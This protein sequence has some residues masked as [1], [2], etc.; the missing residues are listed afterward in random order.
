MESIETTLFETENS[1]DSI[2]TIFSGEHSIELALQK[3]RTKLLD[4][5]SR[6]SLICYRHPKAKSIQFVDNP[7]INLVFNR[8]VDGKQISIKHVPDPPIESYTGKKPDVKLHAQSLG[9]DINPDIPPKFC[10]SSANKHT[11][12]IQAPF[13][14]A[15]LDRLCR[16]ISSESRTVIE[17]TGSN[18]LYLIC[19]FLEFY[20][21]DDSERPFLAPLLAVPITLDKTGIDQET[22]TYQYA[23]SYSGEDIHENQTLREKLKEFNLQ[24]PEYNDEDEP[25]V[26]FEELAK[27]VKN[28]KRWKVKYQITL[29]FLSFAKLAIW[30][31]LD[32]KK[33][34]RLL[35]HPLLKDLFNGGGSSGASLTPEDYDIDQHP[36]GDLPLIYDADSSQ[37]SA[38]IDVMAGKNMVINGPP[39][40][41]KSQTITNI[42]ASGLNA[43]KKVLFVSEKMAAL[44]VVKHR[45]NQ[46]NLGHFCLELHS[47]KT[48]KK[49]I[50]NDIQERLD[51]IFQDPQQIQD[52]LVTLNR[53]KSDL[54]RYVELISSSF[55]NA[56]GLTVYEIFWKTEKLRQDIGELANKVQSLH[57]T[58]A[59][60]WTYDCIEGKRTKLES[61]GNLFAIIGNYD[62]EH[63]WWGFVPGH[64][65]PGDDD[66]IEQIIN[67]A[68]SRAQ[69]LYTL[70][71][72]FQARTNTSEEPS[73]A[74][75]NEINKIIQELPEPPQNIISDILPRIF[76]TNKT[77]TK[78]NKDLLKG[79]ISKVQ[80]ARELQAESATSIRPDSHFNYDKIK[81]EIA[82][83]SKSLLKRTFKTSLD[84]LNDW[85]SD[86]VHA[87]H[88]FKSVASET[89]CKY[90]SINASTI[91]SLDSKLQATQPLT[92]FTQP[93][94]S[95]QDGASILL[96][97]LS[98]LGESLER[99]VAIANRR[100]LKFDYTPELIA[101]LGCGDGIEEILPSVTVNSEV[102]EK[103]KL[104]SEFYFSDLPI[105]ELE[106]LQQKLFKLHEQISSLLEEVTGY[107]SKLGIRFD[108]ALKSVV[109]METIGKISANAPAEL[110]DYRRATFSN[111]ITKELIDKAEKTFNL[112]QS[113]REGLAKEFHLDVLPSKESLKAAILTF[114]KGDSFF[115]ILNSE[116]RAAKKLF[117][118]M[119][120][121]KVSYRAE[122]YESKLTSIVNWLELRDSFETN[123]EYKDT[124]GIMFRG[125][126][127]DFS[128]ITRLYDWYTN[129]RNELLAHPGF[130]EMID[131]TSMNSQTV[132]QLGALSGR[133]QTINSEFDIC[134]ESSRHYFGE[135]ASQMESVLR[136]SGWSEFNNKVH[137]V[138]TGL[139]DG[140]TYLK[141]YVKPHVSPKRSV[142]ILNAMM[143]ITSAKADFDILNDGVKTLQDKL[144]PLLPGIS[145][146]ECTNWR[147]YLSILT[148]LARATT[149]LEELLTAHGDR[150]NTSAKIRSFFVSKLGMDDCISKFA[151]LPD[152][153]IAASWEGYH[154][155]ASKI[156]DSA[157]IL[158]NLLRPI[159]LQGKT[160]YEVVSGL[161]AS[162]NSS[163]IINE[164]N[165]DAETMTIVQDM[166]NGLETELF[167]LEATLSWGEHI[168]NRIRNASLFAFILNS[169]A[170]TNFEWARN[171]FNSMSN[172]IT[173]IYDKLDELKQFGEFNAEDWNGSTQVKT[174]SLLDRIEKAEAKIG[175]VLPWSKYCLERNCCHDDGLSKFVKVLEENTIQYDSIGAVFEFVTYRSIGRK[176]YKKFPEFEGFSGDK[177]EKIR[178]DFV[179]LDKDIICLTGKSFAH[180]IN[181]DKYVPQGIN[182]IK[183]GERTELHL[184][185]NEL[186]KQ[187]RHIPIRQLL[188]RAGKS[189]QALKPCFMMGPLSVA[190]YLQQGVINFDLIVMDEASQL[191]PEESLGAIARGTQ[192][193][194]VGDPKQLPPTSFF[195]R[196]VD[197]GE[198]DDDAENPAVFT[199]T[200][201]ILDI[202]QQ[203]FH[204]VRTLRWHYRSQHESLIA[205][206]N[207]HFYNG[208]L[209][210]FPS[211]YDRNNRLG[212]RYRYIKNGI[213]KDRQNVPEA[214][215]VVDAV[216]E[217][218]LKYP[219]ES[220]GV[221]T[222]NQ[223]Q[224]DLIEDLLDKKL[225]NIDETQAY[226]AQWEEEGM[227]FFVKNLENVQGDER[228]IIFISTTFG[229]APG[230]DKPRQNFGPISR[231]DGWRRLNV[232]FTRSRKKI[233]LFTSMLPEDIVVE[234]KTPAGTKALKEYLDFAKRGILTS[235]DIT[236][237]EADSDFE[238]SVGDMLQG[239]GYEVVPQV[240]V[241]G[242][243][244]DLAVRNPD[245]PGEF[246]AAV[247][248]D[249]ASYHSSKSARDRDRIRQSI[250]ES[251]GWKDRIWRI[252]STDWFYNPKR[253]SEKLLNFLEDRRRISQQEVLDYE[254]E[255]YFEE[256][257]E[258]VE[259][260]P[261]VNGSIEPVVSTSIEELFVEVGDTVTYCNASNGGERHSIMIVDTESNPR[262]NLINENTP[263]AQA[264]LNAAVN[265]EVEMEIKGSPTRIIRV[266][267]IQR[268]GVIFHDHS[269][270]F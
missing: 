36:E 44:E 207:F 130:I 147:V 205:F 82:E 268:Q 178:A 110:L 41:G 128:K 77:K 25:S 142:A 5:S 22:R 8:I 245:K 194:V 163:S 193:V 70:V 60:S 216:V 115:N 62:S 152:K 71:N 166:F 227:P 15:D 9:I 26:Y 112:E 138:A 260:S 168:A 96:Q 114:R 31:D 53:H 169:N 102:I 186:S 6:N 75:I 88:N 101:N 198:D 43:G 3:L 137:L 27:A 104:Y 139:K 150:D 78:N 98:R 17:E 99:V 155:L 171:Q 235:T 52:K 125:T 57:V 86:A 256:S 74:S 177:H 67:E 213:Y 189:I 29:G 263:L 64:L 136:Q 261:E 265:D 79:L 173:S 131:L 144:E 217:H 19:G 196:L 58:D 187:R 68:K 103:A 197:D 127:T 97:E 134:L 141:S 167:S 220:L 42:I 59:N 236:G 126:E 35:T 91:E 170:V 159:G 254:I 228:D 63:A 234:A 92:L 241:A 80:L 93:I 12:K 89:P 267:K 83:N 206:S 154:S 39:G 158:V 54:N 183:A 140:V 119:S 11:P 90:F 264:L 135:I 226:L 51:A 232:L 34:P 185:L 231:P 203:L 55:D 65:A 195:D 259:Q 121:S 210:V 257:E 133:L 116:W 258:I 211:P 161:K 46:A 10:V 45:L 23:I 212:V 100:E 76:T 204:P 85:V 180:R 208:K 66:A 69:E 251:L 247:E 202:C 188:R 95:L 1:G 200:E 244:I 223:T 2:N 117:N 21:S 123:Q 182:S 249:G 174:V 73:L 175:A 190:Q 172:T 164:L 240:G 106:L 38:L 237:K 157:T 201:S 239:R 151:E 118:S 18:M 49:K 28:K 145:L 30:G 181:R 238:I 221:V 252:W 248:C 165:N 250:L 199:G 224:K 246:L 84:E 191:R 40:T 109:F 16:K 262:L 124:F 148:K 105:C 225:R 176:I 146:I 222:L 184:L 179:K 209:I 219:E 108:G 107:A 230:T 253:E 192:L 33:Y 47:H 255:G 215:K 132:S 218:M 162:H 143:E 56:L 24:I 156:N 111:P 149:N 4:L 72:D 13:Y 81:S 50:L 266:L 270:T 48:Q 7:N 229:K 160:S 129:S 233:E 122:Q 113:K 32:H 214:Q 242:F 20:D 87:L 153:D 94:H 37:H 269:P 14:P 243:F 120:I 61:L